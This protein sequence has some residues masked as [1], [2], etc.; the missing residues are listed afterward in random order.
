LIFGSDFWR[1]IPSSAFDAEKK[2]GEEISPP[3]K[4]KDI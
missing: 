4:E 3:F 1:I 2:K